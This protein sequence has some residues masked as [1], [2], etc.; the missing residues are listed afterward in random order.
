MAQ[1]TLKCVSLLLSLN[2]LRA[3]TQILV[4]TNAENSKYQNVGKSQ[5]KRELM[6][7]LSTTCLLASG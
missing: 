5:E 1:L 3:W 7:R 6:A 2:K 4:R